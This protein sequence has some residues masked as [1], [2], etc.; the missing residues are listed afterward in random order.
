MVQKS[1]FCTLPQD[2]LVRMIQ[3]L[4]HHVP[5]S[6]ADGSSWTGGAASPAAVAS[7]AELRE[8]EIMSQGNRIT[9]NS[10]YFR[11]Y[12]HL[13]I[14]D[15]EDS[16]HAYFRRKDRR[17]LMCVQGKFK[18]TVPFSQLYTGQAFNTSIEALPSPPLVSASMKL[19]GGLQP[20]LCVNLSS[21]KPFILTPLM[22]AAQA[23]VITPA[24][25]EPPTLST[26]IDRDLNDDLTPLGPEF[27]KMSSKKR[28]RHFG[29]RRR[30]KYV[31]DTECTYT[32]TFYSGLLDLA[33]FRAKLGPLRY[34]LSKVLGARPFQLSVVA[35]DPVESRKKKGKRA[36]PKRWPFVWNLEV[37]NTR[38]IP[39]SIKPYLYTE[40]AI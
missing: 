33:E 1:D 16:P 18:R 40:M 22:A 35:W 12:A 25:C 20:G 7:L 19:L 37:W 5:L 6:G 11:G 15:L 8:D 26:C 4:S 2:D 21:D 32:F 13:L 9:L 39:E 30:L 34:D 23:V 17:Y 31:V 38:G 36:R 3:P 10:D 24:T 29:S 27:E 14:A 28:R